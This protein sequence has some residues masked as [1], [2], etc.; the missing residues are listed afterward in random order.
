MPSASTNL[1]ADEHAYIERRIAIEAV[2]LSAY[3][4]RLVQLDMHRADN[5]ALMALSLD[6][7]SETQH[8]HARSLNEC[9]ALLHSGFQSVSD[10]LTD[11]LYE[12]A[13]NAET[14]LQANTRLLGVHEA[15]ADLVTAALIDC[16][17]IL[18]ATNTVVET[19]ERRIKALG[20]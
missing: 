12:Q 2:S 5:D 3:L 6:A 9:Q 8:A 4:R 10:Q 1:S 16:R 20:K 18:D 7:M 13:R 14:V 11:L 19:I 17:D 15:T